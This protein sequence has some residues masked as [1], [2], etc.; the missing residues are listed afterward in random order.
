MTKINYVK[1]RKAG[2]KYLLLRTYTHKTPF[3]GYNCGN[4]YLWLLPDGTLVIRLGYRWDG[5]SGPAI[6]TE[7]FMRGS[8][9]HDALYQLIR[10]GFLPL[11][12]RAWADLELRVICLE[13]G[14][15][16]VRAWWVYHAVDIFGEF[17]MMN[18]YTKE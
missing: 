2:Y 9:V 6:D 17:F 7:T 11:D 1:D 10:E 18:R 5:A 16:P 14:M 8:L 13:D 3:V 12:D 15:W 4:E